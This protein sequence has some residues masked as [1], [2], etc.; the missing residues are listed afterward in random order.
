MFSLSKSDN[1]LIKRGKLAF[2]IDLFP[3]MFPIDALVALAS[4]T[5]AAEAFPA[6]ALVALTSVTLVAL[7]MVAFPTIPDVE[8]LD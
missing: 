6:V 8:V 7:A 2:D 3:V 1:Q 4:V 5:L